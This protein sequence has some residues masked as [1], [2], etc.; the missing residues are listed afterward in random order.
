M[1]FLNRDDLDE[2]RLTLEC[3]DLVLMDIFRAL[4]ISWEKLLKKGEEHVDILEDKIYENPA[5]ESRAP[6][7]WTNSSLWLKIEKL[8]ALQTGVVSDVQLQMKD[9]ADTEEKGVWFKNTPKDLNRISDLIQEE[10]IKP[11]AALSD[12]VSFLSIISHHTRRSAN[13]DQMYKSVGIRDARHS[14]ELGTSMWRLSWIT[15]IFLPLT[16]IGGFFGYVLRFISI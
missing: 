10:L 14:I 2:P 5:D 1:F 13:G 6:E 8:I 12:L 3:M 11:T 4:Q 16:F 9:L 7:L 15:F